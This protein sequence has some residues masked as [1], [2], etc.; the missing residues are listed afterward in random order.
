MHVSNGGAYWKGYMSD[1]NEFGKDHGLMGELIKT[2]RRVGMERKDWAKLAHNVEHLREVLN[3]SRGRKLN[4]HPILA[5]QSK[6]EQIAW[7]ANAIKE[8]YP[9]I[10]LCT[11]C[12]YYE[13]KAKGENQ[14]L[15]QILGR[16]GLQPINREGCIQVGE[17]FHPM[18]E[19]LFGIERCWFVGD[20]DLRLVEGADSQGFR[21]NPEV[22][23]CL[24]AVATELTD[25]AAL[26]QL[27]Q[28]CRDKKAPLRIKICFNEPERL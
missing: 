3:F 24:R 6:E 13:R 19:E 25:V 17:V 14:R 15:N 10:G 12:G 11:N 28:L 8:L 18:C 9:Y 5:S 23:P 27:S 20:Y 22:P 16:L 26:K 1:K 4:E 2:G 7:L 21:T